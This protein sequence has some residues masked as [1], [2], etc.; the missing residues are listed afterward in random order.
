MKK[1]FLLIIINVFLFAFV[2]EITALVGKAYVLR[3]NKELPIKIGF[4]I[5]NKDEIITNKQTQ[6]QIMFKDNSIITLGENSRF[7]VDDYFFP[8][9][10]NKFRNINISVSNAKARFKL[11]NGVMKAISGEIG[12][13]A[14]K[15]FRIETK[16][17]SIGIRGTYFGVKYIKNTT[18]VSVLEGKIFVIDKINNKIFNLAGGE[19]LILKASKKAKPIIKKQNSGVNVVNVN[20]S[21]S[22]V[23]DAA[24]EQNSL[25][26]VQKAKNEAINILQKLYSSEENVID[27]ESAEE[28]NNITEEANNVNENT[29]SVENQNSDENV[30]TSNNNND[31]TVNDQTVA[32]T[33][34]NEEENI[35]TNQETESDTQDGVTQDNTNEEM[36]IDKPSIYLTFIQRIRTS[37]ENIPNFK[38][39]KYIDDTPVVKVSTGIQSDIMKFE[40]VPQ[41]D[42]YVKVHV[43]FKD[44]GGNNINSDLFF[45]VV[46]NRFRFD[47]VT[48]YGRIDLVSGT[49]RGRF[50]G[51][52]AEYYNIWTLS[53]T[54]EYN[55]DYSAVSIVPLT[56]LNNEEN[57][58]YLYSP[59]AF[60]AWVIKD[61][62][63][64][65]VKN[66]SFETPQE[67]IDYLSAAKIYRKFSDGSVIDFNNLSFK[68]DNEIY[69]KP[70][71]TESDGFIVFDNSSQKRVYKLKNIE[72]KIENN[73]IIITK[74]D[75]YDEYN[76][77]IPINNIQSDLKIFSANAIAYGG[78]V[79]VTTQDGEEIV[80]NMVGK[81]I[82]GISTPEV[83]LGY[84][85]DEDENIIDE[86][87][88][89]L[90]TIDDEITELISGKIKAQYS[91]NIFGVFNHQKFNGTINMNIDFGNRNISG[92]FSFLDYKVEFNG[93]INSDN[94]VEA[95]NFNSDDLVISSG[96]LD[97]KFYGKHAESVA[98][99]INLETDKGELKSLYGVRR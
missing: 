66:D 48:N 24:S 28:T 36:D 32:D 91:G 27:S 75:L 11:K 71:E 40:I 47:S 38:D 25:K 8:E 62:S 82:D 98:G 86:Y 41:S 6:L 90:K 26:N 52:D 4:K 17:V 74:A 79:V 44:A 84:F 78:E 94:A 95:Q 93:E 63:I 3:N 23:S 54:T 15:K 5:E 53:V 96:N 70:I 81:T 92:D 7:V 57:A 59:H 16:N 64:E 9:R 21:S 56:Y 73:Q 12:K 99:H 22:N 89:G 83:E 13:I 14:P 33:E 18:I 88:T 43:E 2:G 58:D 30:Q 50:L 69:S 19:T 76:N 31:E 10:K 29:E 51:N 60:L 72:G 77:L 39:Y 20:D 68:N 87:I 55:N 35:V 85:Y 1:I 65:I 46:N 61:N 97:G 67:M 37:D 45:K 80:F 34:S 42:D 49:L